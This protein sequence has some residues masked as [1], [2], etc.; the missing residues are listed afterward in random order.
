MEPVV[1]LMLGVTMGLCVG[2]G[3]LE[4]MVVLVCVTF[5][6]VIPVVV[7]VVDTVTGGRVGVEWEL[8]VVEGASVVV[9][10]VEVVSG[11]VPARWGPQ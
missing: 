6:M 11:E 8:V 7:V 2:T 5:E 1:W 4:A 3:T 9:P 10:L